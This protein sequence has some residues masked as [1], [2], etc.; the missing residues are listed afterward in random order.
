[1]EG[2]RRSLAELNSPV[3][4]SQSGVQALRNPEIRV[5]RRVPKSRQN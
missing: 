1:M 5:A 2:S 3:A 4:Y